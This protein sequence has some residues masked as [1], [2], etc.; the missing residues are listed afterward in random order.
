M[1]ES[2]FKRKI[3]VV[4]FSSTSDSWRRHWGYRVLKSSHV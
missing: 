4:L 3:Y 2:D 1:H